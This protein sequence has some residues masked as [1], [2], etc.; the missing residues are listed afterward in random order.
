MDDEGSAGADTGQGGG[1]QGFIHRR[2]DPSLKDCCG[3]GSAMI[4]IAM[5]RVT[6]P[7]PFHADPDPGVEKA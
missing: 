5:A 1:G 3:S 6:N 4:Y 7:P 2:W